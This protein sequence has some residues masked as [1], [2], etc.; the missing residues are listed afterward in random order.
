MAPH[1]LYV[2]LGGSR[3]VEKQMTLH[4]EGLK[5]ICHMVCHYSKRIRSFCIW[6]LSA[7]L[8][9]TPYNKA[10]SANKRTVELMLSGRLFIYRRKSKGAR[11]VPWGTPDVTEA[12]IDDLPSQITICCLPS[13][14]D[15]NQF[16]NGPRIP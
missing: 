6:S 8:E 13:K 15:V 11:T 14:S 5:F 10:S 4:L 16:N 3:F 9:I 2:F 7:S 12:D 1:S